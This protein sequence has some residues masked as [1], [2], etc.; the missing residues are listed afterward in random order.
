MPGRGAQTRPE[1]ASAL[2]KKFVNAKAW[3]AIVREAES[4]GWP[5]AYAADLYEHDLNYIALYLPNEASF[6]WVVRPSGTHIFSATFVTLADLEAGYSD[7]LRYPAIIERSFAPNVWF[8]WDGAGL[9]EVRN[10]DEMRDKLS[11]AIEA[12][13]EMFQAALK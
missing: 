2:R 7:L 13:R 4:R 3:R 12:Q 11:D 8:W 1:V 6:G 10:A 5:E 9:Q